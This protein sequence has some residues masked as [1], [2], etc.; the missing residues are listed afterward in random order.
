M[1]SFVDSCS[2][3]IPHLGFS[4]TKDMVSVAREVEYFITVVCRPRQITVRVLFS[5][6][7]PEYKNE[8]MTALSVKYAFRQEFTA[9]GTSAQNG[10]AERANRTVT[11]MCRAMLFQSAS[12]TSLC[13]WVYDTLVITPTAPRWRCGE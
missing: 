6:N 11:E 10:L 3:A 12:P 2:R 7:G 4:A 13:A 8:L 9:P 1:I 5:D